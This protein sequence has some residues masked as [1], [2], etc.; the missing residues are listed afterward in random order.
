M[1]LLG[2]LLMTTDCGVL[3]GNTSFECMCTSCD[4]VGVLNT[5]EFVIFLFGVRFCMCLCLCG[6]YSNLLINYICVCTYSLF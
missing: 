5:L 3:G 2:F 6:I 4:G 1:C